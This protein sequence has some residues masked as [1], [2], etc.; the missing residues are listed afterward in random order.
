MGNVLAWLRCALVCT[1]TVTRRLAGTGGRW[2][3]A[4]LLFVYQYLLLLSILLPLAEFNLLR[5]Q[6]LAVQL[7]TVFAV[8]LYT[9]FAVQLYTVFA[10]QLHTVFAVQL[11]TH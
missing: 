10:V 11:Y 9:V 4:C 6:I 1:W 7:Y 8:Q 2:Q 5:K 3:T